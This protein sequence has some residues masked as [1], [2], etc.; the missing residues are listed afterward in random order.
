MLHVQKLTYKS[1]FQIYNINY[2]C[3]VPRYTQ[4][5]DNIECD[6]PKRSLAQVLPKVSGL[7]NTLQTDPY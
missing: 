2:L 1:N 3:V 7:G 6:R 5:R 4:S